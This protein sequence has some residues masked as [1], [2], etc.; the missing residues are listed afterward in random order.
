MNPA[1]LATPPVV[2]RWLLVAGLRRW[3]SAALAARA[4]RQRAAEMQS[5]I[6]WGG[7]AAAWWLAPAAFLCTGCLFNNPPPTRYFTPPSAI[8]AADDPP[9]NHATV[10][11]VRLRRVHAAAYL[12]EQIVWRGSDVE[13]GLYEQR[14]WTEF[15][16]RYLERAMKRAL[17]GTPGV[18]RVESGRVPTLDLELISFDEILAPAHA[19]DVTVVASL[20]DAEHTLFERSF[21]A[22]RAIADPDPA[23]AARA[24][25]AALDEVVRQIATEVAAQ[26]PPPR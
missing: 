10:R 24:M 2:G 12:A 3:F 13:R 15:P 26:T 6:R 20:R 7:G 1:P 8:A 4:V 5:E 17:D 23:S 11:L 9:A 14:R 22:Q 16:S 18:R 25:G 21:T 19:A